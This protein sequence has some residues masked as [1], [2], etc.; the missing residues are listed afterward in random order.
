MSVDGIK[1]PVL[2][3]VTFIAACRTFFGPKVGQDLKGFVEEMRAL[4]P[5]DKAD[6]IEMFKG[7]GLD[8]SRTS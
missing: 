7:E 3:S 4:T 6:L 5:S 8:A 2:K 1:V